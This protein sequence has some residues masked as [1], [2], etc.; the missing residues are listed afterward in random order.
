VGQLCWRVKGD[1]KKVFK[2]FI[3]KLTLKESVWRADISWGDEIKKG[4]KEICVECVNRI[5][6]TRFRCG[7]GRWI[8]LRLEWHRLENRR[9]SLWKVRCVALQDTRREGRRNRR[10]VYTYSCAELNTA[11]QRCMGW[12]EVQFEPFLISVL[13]VDN[14]LNSRFGRLYP[15]YHRVGGSERDWIV[16]RTLEILWFLTVSVKIIAYYCGSCNGGM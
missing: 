12:I 5:E 13:G 2:C 1:E 11:I 3:A 8:N 16:W 4:I 6:L 15:S 9:G 14:C 7:S 10:T